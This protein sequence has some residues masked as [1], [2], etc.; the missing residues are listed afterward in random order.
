MV[1]WTGPPRFPVRKVGLD[2]TAVFSRAKGWTGLDR[3]VFS[4]ERLDWTGPPRFLVRKVGLDRTAV[5]S[6]SKGW[7]G[8]NRRIFSFER[9]DWTGPLWFFWVG[10]RTGSRIGDECLLPQSLS[11]RSRVGRPIMIFGFGMKAAHKTPWL[12]N[13]FGL[14][15]NGN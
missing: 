2:R 1:G 3:R 6:R 15:A 9:L 5:F 13:R 10:L 7:T 11:P 4:F 8:P 12:V 14:R